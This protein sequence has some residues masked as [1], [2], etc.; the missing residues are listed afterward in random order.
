MVLL[1]KSSV[2]HSPRAVRVWVSSMA[3]LRVADAA[4]TAQGRWVA[5][6]AAAANGASMARLS[7]WRGPDHEGPLRV[8]RVPAAAV[9]AE[10]SLP[11]RQR[12]TAMASAAPRPATAV[13]RRGQCR[14]SAR[15][16]A[17][18]ASAAPPS[19]RPVTR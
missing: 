12:V 5:R 10:M 16:R 19:S 6:V 15:R 9:V 17:S 3:A 13:G 7:S 11:P 4:R 8:Q 18:H 1:A 2:S 14:W